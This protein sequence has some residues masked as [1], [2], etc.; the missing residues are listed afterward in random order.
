MPEPLITNRELT[1]HPEVPPDDEG[2][3]EMRNRV[4]LFFQGVFLTTLATVGASMMPASAS[5]QTA[6]SPTI[7]SCGCTIAKSGSYKIG[8]AINSTQG[9]TPAGACIEIAASFVFL[10]AG[11]KT[12]TGPGGTTP[13]GIGIW[14]H[15]PFRSIFLE[16]RGT[17]ISGWDVGLLIQ[18]RQVV[19]D[20]FTANT[21]GSAGIE[22]NN[23]EG[24]E[25]TS[26]TASSNLNYGIWVKQTSISDITN[27]KTLTNGNIGLYVG[28]SDIGPVSSGCPG[29][30]PSPGNYIFTGGIAGNT[31]YGVALDFGAKSTVV[32]NQ[33]LSGGT[34]NS[35]DDLFDANSSCG[36]NKWFADDSTATNNQAG[37]CIK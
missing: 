16:G 36:S 9:L 4:T 11:K 10:D 12:V 35:K 37:G 24:V 22:L 23:A 33:T 1:G 13:T 27:S 20:D 34:H 18:G 15:H 25:L 32:T 31:N 17:V 26:P 8:L 21:N 19:A 6:C 30:G 2:P 14:V 7:N 5:A 28:C 29:V 3:F